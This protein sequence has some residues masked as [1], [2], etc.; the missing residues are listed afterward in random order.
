MK[1][2]L[3]VELSALPSSVTRFGEIPPLWQINKNIGNIFKVYLVWVKFSTHFGT[4]CMLLGT[5]SLLKMA[6]Y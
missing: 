2:Y 4:I 1:Q 6:K 5:L 3:R